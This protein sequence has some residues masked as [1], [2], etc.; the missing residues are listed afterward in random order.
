M[1]RI[2]K[3]FFTGINYWASKNATH[4]WRDYD[5]DVIENDMRLLKEAG[6]SMLRIFPSWDDFQPLTAFSA[7]GGAVYEYG[8]NGDVKP[9]TEA[10][11]AGV[12]EIMCE[13]FENFCKIAEKY[14]MGIIV[15]VLT[16]HM[17]FANLIPPALVN[18]NIFTNPQALRWEMK[19]INYI[20]GRFKKIPNIIA[21]DLGNEI[22]NLRDNNT[23]D[24]FYIWSSMISNTIRAA[25][26]SRPVISGVGGFVIERG[27]PN[28][29]DLKDVCDINTV[30]AY[31]IFHSQSDPI[32]SMVPI[33]DNIFKC[34]L[35][36]DL[37][38][39]PTF[40]QEFGATGY[41]NC[42]KKAEAEFYRACTLSALS[43]GFGGIMY[44]CA[45]DQG[46]L[47]F[48]PY[49][50]NNIGSNYGFYDS[51]LK[52]KPLAKENIKLSDLID[53][54][55]DSLPKNKIN[56]TIIAARDEGDT[57][58]KTLRAAYILAKRANLEPGFA[59]ALDELPESDVYII[60]SV[61]YNKAITNT[62]MNE[63]LSRVKKGASL[64]I[65]LGTALF[66]DIEKLAGV[67]IENRSVVSN[68]VR[69]KL[70]NSTLPVWSSVNF[71]IISAESEILGTD[72][73]EQPIFVKNKYGDGNI[74]VLFA[75]IEEFISS[76]NG[77]FYKNGFPDY[78]NIY[79]I[80]GE[81]VKNKKIASCDSK[82]IL[83]T[84]HTID[85]NSFYIFAVNY[86]TEKNSTKLT[87]NG[88]YNLSSEW[89]GNF[90]NGVITLEPC[91]GIIIKAEKISK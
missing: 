84:E 70:D 43:H 46:H 55:G 37:G 11:R 72:A 59:Y 23:K 2:S 79:R 49:N 28:I 67:C 36:E 26:S 80:I 83:H 87:L 3:K 29:Y 52:I 61:K 76:K 77:I 16:G 68:E 88:D 62:R 75:P 24:Q 42:S 22:E 89:G 48:P 58:T 10:G 25:D 30:H 7:P 39:M 5:S 40:L 54:L 56:C 82:F 47:T 4:M 14:G 8:M 17:S 66:R 19:Y 12:D 27:F 35:S 20:I 32:N 64:Y 85:E 81:D 90:N 71:N 65:S 53:K 69:I 38:K 41:T 57:Q 78:E 34:R 31:N 63:L 33:L 21:W 73:N 15:G 91:D 18:L 13:R 50:W 74:Y 51:E 45:F 1:N 44:W 86:S 6:I 9:D 60:P